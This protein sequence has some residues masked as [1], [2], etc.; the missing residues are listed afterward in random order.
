MEECIWCR[1]PLT[2]PETCSSCG[3]KQG[4]E[5]ELPQEE[6]HKDKT[7][8]LSNKNKRFEERKDPFDETVTGNIAVGIDPGARH[9][10]V[11]V[12]DNETVLESSTYRRDDEKTSTEWAIQNAEI[13]LEYTKKYPQAIIGVEGIND[14]KGFNKKGKAPLNPKDIIRTGIALGAIVASVRNAEII[15]PDMNGDLHVSHYPSVLCGRRP[16]NLK[17]TYQGSTRRHEKSAYDIARKLWL[18]HHSTGERKN[19]E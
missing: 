9:T 18:L 6:S 14:P 1:S 15:S 16:P 8:R 19:N 17:G 5:T 13:A 3:G 4:Q 7:Y 2:D 11:C 10:A 12:V